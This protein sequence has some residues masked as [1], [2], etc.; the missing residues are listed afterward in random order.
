[1]PQDTVISSLGNNLYNHNNPNNPVDN[2]TDDSSMIGG[3]SQADAAILVVPA[4]SEFTGG[5]A[6][7]GQTK[8]HAILARSL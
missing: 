3:T 8:E 2:P 1:M 4:G 7:N 6:H 5:F